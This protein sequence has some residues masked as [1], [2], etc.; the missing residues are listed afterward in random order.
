[1]KLWSPQA[2][3]ESASRRGKGSTQRNRDEF[4]S[5]VRPRAD[6]LLERLCELSQ[7]PSSKSPSWPK[8]VLVGFLSLTL[9]SSDSCGVGRGRLLLEM[10]PTLPWPG[11]REVQSDSCPDI[12]DL[13]RGQTVRQAV[14]TVCLQHRGQAT[15]G[16]G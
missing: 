14:L 16:D 11:E 13:Q 10:Q 5:L 7:C 1:M 2:H 15:E 3:E 4:Q 6:F 12:Q 8:P 9:E